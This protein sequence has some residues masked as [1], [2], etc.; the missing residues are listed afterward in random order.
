[1]SKG[2]ALS[3][4]DTMVVHSDEM[5]LK[6]TDMKKMECK[7]KWLCQYSLGWTLSS[8]I[9]FEGREG[10]NFDIHLSYIQRP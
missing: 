8:K 2:I 7:A 9:C 4:K 1:V 5:S 6:E 10:D 3:L